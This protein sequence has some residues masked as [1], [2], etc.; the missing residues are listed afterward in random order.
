MEVENTSG[1]VGVEHTFGATAPENTF[2][3]VGFLRV[4]QLLSGYGPADDKIDG[5][6]VIKLEDRP[7]E[8]FGFK[9]RDDPDGPAHEA[10]FSLL[11]LA[12]LH[13]L[14]VS[15]DYVRDTAAGKRNGRIVR[16]WLER[17]P[18]A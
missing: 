9:L 15:F 17:P 2:G 6:V 14:P 4:H 7:S 8:A 11:K 3:L 12:F 5:E 13:R 1:V 18:S 10:M 16:V